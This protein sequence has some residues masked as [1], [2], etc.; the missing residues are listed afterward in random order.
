MCEGSYGLAAAAAAAAAA[1]WKNIRVVGDM[2]P[3]E[4]SRWC[5]CS[6]G[7]GRCDCEGG[8][9]DLLRGLCG[10]SVRCL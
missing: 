2:R 8:G 10:E 4:P 9:C 1:A 5:C 3:A 7:G 6:G